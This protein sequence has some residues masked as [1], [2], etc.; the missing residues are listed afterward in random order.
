MRAL[1]NS[2]NEI[3]QYTS[4]IYEPGKNAEVDKLKWKK[5]FIGELTQKNDMSYFT[6]LESVVSPTV[7]SLDEARGYVVADYQDYLEKEL[8]K[9]LKEKFEVKVN[10]DVLS[11]LIKE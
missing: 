10:E 3:V 9:K 7:K 8:I 11:S 6:K 4:G 5:G 2:D 1:F